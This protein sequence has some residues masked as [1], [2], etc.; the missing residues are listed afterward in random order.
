[1]RLSWVIK[2]MSTLIKT[3][4]NI[5]CILTLV[6]SCSS[7]LSNTSRYTLL[8]SNVDYQGSSFSLIGG[9]GVGPID[10]P[11]SLGRLEVVS[12]GQGN[13]I[14]INSQHIWAGGLR[15]SISRI[16]AASISNRLDYD[17]VWPFPWDVRTRPETQI[18]LVVQHLGGELGGAVT[19]DAKWKLLNQKGK[20]IV[21]IGHCRFSQEAV[22]DTYGS[23]VLAINHLIDLCSGVLIQTLESRY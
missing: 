15:K 17:D 13:Q 14:I 18:H 12:L 7:Q 20:N 11:E 19:L 6:A 9:L 4:L 16:M 2:K 5:A 1:M 22:D 21:S 8:P 10:L 23:Y 3:I